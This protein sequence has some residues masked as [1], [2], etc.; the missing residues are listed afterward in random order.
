MKATLD[1]PR[2]I[3]CEYEVYLPR[4]G[5]TSNAQ[6]QKTLS[7]ILTAN[8]LPSVSREYCHAPIPAGIDF[9]VEYDSSIRGTFR[10][11]DVAYVSVEVK[12]RILRD[13]AEWE[14]LVPK[15]LAI[16]QEMGARVNQSCG[17]HLHIGVPEIADDPRRIRS[18]YNLFWRFEPTVF[19]LVSPSRR[20]CRYASAMPAGPQRLAGCRTRA[21]FQRALAG[22]ER[23]HG[24]NLTHLFNGSPRIELRYHQGT[25][26]AEKARHW[27]RFCL[28]MVEHAVRRNCRNAAQLANSR[29]S[30][31]KMLIACGFKP[32]NGIYHQVCPELRQTGKYL[33]GRW[34]HFNGKIALKRAKG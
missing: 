7:D 33:L 20:N 16:L 11:R 31:E 5:A 30:I 25:I 24:L 3:G 18:I 26:N 14:R 23:Y 10:F 21:A 13:Y 6:V 8:G 15:A 4:L 28:Q 29:E 27:L 19:G 22:W 34:K 9:A 2:P 32:N 17:H 12:T 1:Q